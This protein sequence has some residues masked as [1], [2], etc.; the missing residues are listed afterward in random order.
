MTFKTGMVAAGL[1]AA[2]TLANFVAGCAPGMTNV[3][4]GNYR[5]PLNNFVM[6]VPSGSGTKINERHDE[7]S[8]AVSFYDEF[9]NNESVFY[10]RL[11]ADAGAT[12]GDATKRDA[13]YRGFLHDYLMPSYFLPVSANAKV[14]R[15]EFLYAGPDRAY[16]AVV[17]IPEA[18]AV[19]D[20]QTGKRRDA[21]RDLMVFYQNSFMYALSWEFTDVFEKV[22]PAPLLN[23]RVEAS[24]TALR[25]MRQSIRFQ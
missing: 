7:R 1:L 18:S 16:F 11:P 15:E 20:G 2:T 8:G 22:A 19:V 23:S 21:V 6:P 5:A 17:V 10:G 13:A 12:L 14:V 24:Q 25:R 9:G 4:G 3:S